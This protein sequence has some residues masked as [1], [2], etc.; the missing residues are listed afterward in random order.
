[1]SGMTIYEVADRTAGIHTQSPAL[2]NL[3]VACAIAAYGCGVRAAHAADALAGGEG[4]FSIGV[5]L[6]ETY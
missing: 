2:I 5:L 3:W 1:M 6:P 4:A